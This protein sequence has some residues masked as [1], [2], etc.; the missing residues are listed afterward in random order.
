[1]TESDQP[2]SNQIILLQ[3]ELE[4][5]KEQIA[6][7][8]QAL[9]SADFENSK[10]IQDNMSL[11]FELEGLQASQ[12]KTETKI[13]HL[14]RKRA[15]SLNQVKEMENTI[16][17]NT[18]HNLNV[19][20]DQQAYQESSR[21]SAKLL[22]ES[23]ISMTRQL[24]KIADLQERNDKL[25]AQNEEYF[26]QVS[27]PM[28]VQLED[29]TDFDRKSELFEENVVKQMVINVFASSSQIRKDAIHKIQKFL[30]QEYGK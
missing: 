24:M 16:A 12:K 9:K 7:L 20:R 22:C 29:F 25:V 23:S 11:R 2:E 19:S 27:L 30:N 4:E 28:R 13:T 18:S 5:A 15:L 8:E 3:T 6:I 26:Q 10:L 1:M 17:I 21:L 14:K